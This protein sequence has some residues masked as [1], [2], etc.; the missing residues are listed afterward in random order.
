MVEQF[1]PWVQNVV[2]RLAFTNRIYDCFQTCIAFAKETIN[3]VLWIRP[4]HYWWRIPC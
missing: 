1:Y 4:Q 2:L 3:I